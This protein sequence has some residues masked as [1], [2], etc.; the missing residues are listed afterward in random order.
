MENMG[1]RELGRFQ[2]NFPRKEE[3]QLVIASDMQDLT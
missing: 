2:L 1:F 3:P